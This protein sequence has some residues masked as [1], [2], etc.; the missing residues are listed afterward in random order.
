M[1]DDVEKS[2][3]QSKLA[4]AEKRINKLEHELQLMT[5]QKDL[6]AKESVSLHRRMDEFRKIISEKSDLIHSKCIEL[7]RAFQVQVKLE[8]ELAKLKLKITQ[9]QDAI[10]TKEN[11]Q[12]A[13]KK[14]LSILP[15]WEKDEMKDVHVLF[16]KYQALVSE[17]E[18]SASHYRDCEEVLKAIDD[19]QN[20]LEIEAERVER[21]KLKIEK[22]KEEITYISNNIKSI[23]ADYEYWIQNRDGISARA[24]KLKYLDQ[25][26]TK[27]LGD[28]EQEIDAFQEKT[29]E[30]YLLKEKFLQKEKELER[31]QKWLR[32]E[33][34]QLRKQEKQMYDY[35][36]NVQSKLYREIEK[37]EQALFIIRSLEAIAPV[38]EQVVT[39]LVSCLKNERIQYIVFS[40]MLG[41]S[42]YEIAQDIDT[43]AVNVKRTYMLAIDE[44][45]K[46]LRK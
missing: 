11:E 28:K 46:R 25:D 15:A 3:K 35:S 5:K 7:S 10:D 6:L 16:E 23:Y 27:Q 19:Q 33:E 36:V 34:A 13:L 22:D 43:L 30:L 20:I 12:I 17:I 29:E 18:M 9:Q 2:E 41:K 42:F 44:L 39:N 1:F 38:Y 4:I 26:I 8:K 24:A 32:Q 37:D 45:S 14:A 31:E 21:K 40:Y